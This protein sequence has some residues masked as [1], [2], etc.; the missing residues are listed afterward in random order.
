MLH[1]SIKDAILKYI[2]L[3]NK[4]YFMEFSIYL[5]PKVTF[6]PGFIIDINIF[7]KNHDEKLISKFGDQRSKIKINLQRS[8]AVI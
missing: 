7:M 6:Y 2:K 8:P 5:S 1:I 4:M 3:E